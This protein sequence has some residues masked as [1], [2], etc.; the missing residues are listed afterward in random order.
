M[1]FLIPLIASLSLIMSPSPKVETKTYKC[2][3]SYKVFQDNRLV[4]HLDCRS[5]YGFDL[6]VRD[7]ADVEVRLLS[8]DSPSNGTYTFYLSDKAADHVYLGY[9]T[10]TARSS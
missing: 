7:V 5:P 8:S 2:E 3:A 9:L 4:V 10:L 1:S 6:Y